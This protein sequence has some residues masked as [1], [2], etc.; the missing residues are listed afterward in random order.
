M[1]VLW[2]VVYL[3]Y[4]CGVLC[5]CCIVM[6]VL[7]SVVYALRSVMY[8]MHYVMYILR[9]LQGFSGGDTSGPQPDHSPDPGLGP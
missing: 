5:M 1:F 8:V 7:W 6:Y 3:M 4:V 9:V 2:N